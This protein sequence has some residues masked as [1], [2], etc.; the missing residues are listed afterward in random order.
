MFLYQKSNFPK[1]FVAFLTNL[2]C[3]S[4]GLNAFNRK[5]GFE[6]SIAWPVWGSTMVEHSPLHL[7]VSGLSL[8]ANAKRRYS[9]DVRSCSLI[10]FFEPLN[11]L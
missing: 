8:A 10:K 11:G 7:K 4:T 1:D 3:S 6:E 5:L 9:C 2:E